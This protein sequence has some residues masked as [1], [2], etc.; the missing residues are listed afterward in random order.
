MTSYAQHVDAQQVV[1]V[2]IGFCARTNAL[3]KRPSI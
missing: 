1:G 2:A 3:M